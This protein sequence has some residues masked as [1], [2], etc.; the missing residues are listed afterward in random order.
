M[1][2]DMVT[3]EDRKAADRP[4]LIRKQGYWYRPNASGYTDSAIQAGRYSL[5][6]AERYTHPNGKDGPRDGMDYVHEDDLTCPDWLAYK[7]AEQRGYQQGME[8][9][10]GVADQTCLPSCRC[11]GEAVISEYS[12]LALNCW[13]VECA[14]G[15]E[16]AGDGHFHARGDSELLAAQNWI[17]TAI[18]AKAEEKKHGTR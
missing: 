5:E 7:A 3:D 12:G 9:A 15:L 1:L 4:Y 16:S 17:A 14:I 13:V 10:A 2:T 18:R 11:G 8:E 6:E